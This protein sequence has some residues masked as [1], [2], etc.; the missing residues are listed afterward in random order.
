MHAI[1]FLEAY[2]IAMLKIAYLS[3]GLFLDTQSGEDLIF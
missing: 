3:A 1:F 2:Q